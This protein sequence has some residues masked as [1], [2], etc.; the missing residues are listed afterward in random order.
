MQKRPLWYTIWLVILALLTAVYAIT[1]DSFPLQTSEIRP[2]ALF[3]FAMVSILC[4]LMLLTG[5]T[6]WTE[7]PGFQSI[8][9]KSSE[10]FCRP[11][12]Y[13]FLVFTMAGCIYAFYCFALSP[14]T[15]ARLWSFIPSGTKDALAAGLL[16][17]A[18]EAA[19]ARPHRH[20]TP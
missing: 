3:L 19:S 16:F 15:V 2:F 13:R 5:Y 14:V 18:A 7:T 8:P 6:E 10:A 9:K 1:P 12:F 20:P 4:A 17:C 11:A